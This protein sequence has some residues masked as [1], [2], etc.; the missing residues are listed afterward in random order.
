M[1]MELVFIPSPGD[2]HLRPLVEVA[3]LLVD[4]DDHLSITIIII[5][6]MHGFSSGNSS[7]YI[8]SLSSASEERLRYNVLSVPDKPAS[9]DSKPHFFDYIDGFKPQV[10]ATVE[11]LT[12]PAQP[13]SPPRLAGIV[14]DMFCTMMIDVANE[15]RVP[16]YMFYTS[17]AT[18]LGLQV[19]I[20]YLY[21]VKN[22]DVSDLKDSD[23]TE[24]E[25]P[26]LTRPLPVKCFP[27]VLLTKEW[28]P[29]LFSQTRR[30]R[31]TKGILVN[32]FAE[33]EPQAMKFFSGVDSPLPTVYTVGPV[34]NLKINGTI[35]S[36]DKQS[37][38]LRWLDEQP[39]TSVVFLC[40]GSMGGFREDQAKEIAIALERSGHRFLWS[41]RRAQPKGTMG[42][43]G[44][45]ANLEEI[46][47]EGFLERTA[48]I[49]QQVNAFEMVEELGL[50]V[51]IRNSFRG[52]FMAADSEL[53]TAE[54][55]ERGIRSLM[56]QDSDVRSR[57]KEM[58]EKSHVALLDGGSSHV[59][60]LKF[61]QDVTK[62]LS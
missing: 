25:V 49:E 24:L 55:I 58:S 19:H 13:E 40:F 48:E 14:V 37:E 56:E 1:K 21:D 10:K 27:S 35:S 17:N 50:A 33:L 46:L 5:P 26:C 15:F 34:I 59:A 12:D 41:L 22:Y 31:E 11:K 54:E 20:Q 28:L 47:P 2:G 16:S 8:A 39:R 3:K 53:M 57:V 38:I 32:T 4:R 6:Q 23:T 30:F 7:S 36:D 18:F 29:V 45:F 43:P 52:D 42:P 44:E 61:I 51:E 60:L 62:N 9:D